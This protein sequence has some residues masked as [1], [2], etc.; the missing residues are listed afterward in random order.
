M[1]CDISSFAEKK[2]SNGTFQCDGTWEPFSWRVYTV[3]A[4][5]AGVRN[6]AGIKPL[7]EPRGLPSDAS[8]VAARMHENQEFG[9]LHST[10]WFMVAELADF[11]YDANVEYSPRHL[12][13]HNYDVGE[14]IHEAGHGQKMTWREFL[15]ATY[16]KD[17]ARLQ[18]TGADRVVFWFGC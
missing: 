1:G 15:D 4:F 14:A 10:S 17:L 9:C 6:Q 5:L 11:D 3:F 8:D 7:S 12:V 13:D 16:F 2:D 18:Q